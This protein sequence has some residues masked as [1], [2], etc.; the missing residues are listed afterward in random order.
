MA[1][2]VF[3]VNDNYRK[4]LLSKTP[5]GSTVYIHHRDGKILSYDKIKNVEAY[6]NKV[7]LDPTVIKAVVGDVTILNEL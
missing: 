4:N 3:R 1:K 5:G 7:F 6:I 2:E